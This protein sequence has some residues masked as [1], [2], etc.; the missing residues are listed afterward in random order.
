[1]GKEK[2]EATQGRPHK[3][4]LLSDTD[5]SF[6]EPKHDTRQQIAE[7]AGVATGTVARAAII[8]AEAN[9]KRSE[10]AKGNDNAAKDREEKTIVVPE[11]QVLNE[12]DRAPGRAARAEDAGVS[13]STMAKVEAIANFSLDLLEKVASG[14]IVDTPPCGTVHGCRRHERHRCRYN[15]RLETIAPCRAF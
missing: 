8:Q 14:E 5:N 7:A 3:E 12:A 11:E 9:R 4:K 13:P 1:M 10:K 15:T 2:R 6:K